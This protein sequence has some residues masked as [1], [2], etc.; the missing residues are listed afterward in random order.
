MPSFTRR[1]PTAQAKPAPAGTIPA[2]SA[3]T[4]PLYLLPTGIP[5]L[6]DLLGGGLLL[7]G[8][9]GILAPDHH[10]AWSRLAERYFIA[11]GLVTGQRSV[12]VGEPGESHDVVA[13]CMWVDERTTADGSESEGEGV[14]GAVGEG[15][16]GMRIAWRYERMKKFQTTI[17]G[18][19]AR[20]SSSYM[21]RARRTSSDPQEAAPSSIS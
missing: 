17:K 18:E 1:T 11:Q 6:D 9:L 10:T 12:V 3:S 20:K 8:I 21:K 15:K 7:G 4:P 19:W 5:S 14:G 13:G 2:L 16:G